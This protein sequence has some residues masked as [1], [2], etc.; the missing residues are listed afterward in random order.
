M[1]SRFTKLPRL[2]LCCSI[3]VKGSAVDSKDGVAVFRQQ[4]TLMILA[5]RTMPSFSLQLDFVDLL[6]P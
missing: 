2:G 6:D 4:F 1:L 3:P 5:E